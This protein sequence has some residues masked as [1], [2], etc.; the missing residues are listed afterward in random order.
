MRKVVN[1]SL[2]SF[3]REYR[4]VTKSDFQAVFAKPY[5]IAHKYLLVLFL[6]NQKSHARIGIIAAKKH[7]KLAVKRNCFRRV[8]RESFKA[9]KE[10]LK[11]LDIIVLI[12]SECTPLCRTT[13]KQ[14]LRE[15]VD[16]LWCLLAKSSKNV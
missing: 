4:L 5:K 10:R 15:D 7:L 12:R 8:V 13:D 6:P 14:V 16:N 3:S 9:H 1:V 2:S 11:G